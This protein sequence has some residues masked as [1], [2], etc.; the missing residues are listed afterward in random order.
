VKRVKTTVQ[1]CQ[2]T[3]SYNVVHS[4]ARSTLTEVIC[5]HASLFE[6]GSTWTLASVKEIEE[7]LLT[8]LEVE[9]WLADSIG[10][11]TRDMLTTV[12][13]FQSSLQFVT[14]VTQAS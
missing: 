1:F 12:A 4:L 5:G 11:S 8:S 6:V 13:A 14:R 2:W 9:S 7:R 3:D 10:S